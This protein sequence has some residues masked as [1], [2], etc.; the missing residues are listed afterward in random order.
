MNEKT[1]ETRSCI[2]WLDEHNI[3]REVFKEGVEIDVED[4]LEILEA[5]KK[6]LNGKKGPILADIRRLKSTTKAARDSGRHEEGARITTAFGILVGS[7]VSRMIGALFLRVVKPIYPTRLF[8]DEKEALEWL[9][10]F[11]ETP[12]GER[13]DDA[14]TTTSS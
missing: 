12:T 6:L 10:G 11:V 1:V 9:K 7:P 2:L 4:T 14:P 13:D 8:T 3:T 5:R